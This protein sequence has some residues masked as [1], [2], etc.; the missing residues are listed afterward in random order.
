VERRIESVGSGE[1]EPL[2]RCGDDAACAEEVRCA[3]K[4]LIDENQGR[5]VDGI[6]GEDVRVVGRV[7]VW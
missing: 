6:D 1:E 3:K 5:W 4:P 2:L 7:R